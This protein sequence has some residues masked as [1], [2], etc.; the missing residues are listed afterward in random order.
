MRGIGGDIKIGAPAA[1]RSVPA[2]NVVGGRVFRSGPLVAAALGVLRH[3]SAQGLPP[4]PRLSLPGLLALYRRHGPRLAAHIGGRFTLVLHDGERRCAYVLQDAAS[5]PLNLYYA[6]GDGLFYFDTS[7]KRLLRRS[8]LPRRP[9]AAGRE[10]FLHNGFIPSERTLLEGVSKLPPGGGLRLDLETGRPHRL[11]RQAPVRR[12]GL[13]AA[14]LDYHRALRRVIASEVDR[15]PRLG[16]GLSG[17]YDSN[18]LLFLLRQARRRGCRL[19]TIGVRDEADEVRRAARIARRYPGVE[20]HVGWVGPHTLQRLPDIVW[21]LEG[22]V[23]ERG[24]F[25]Q[26]EL[27]RLARHEGCRALLCAECADQVLAPGFRA[28]P[29]PH[30]TRLGWATH[31]YEMGLM[32]VLKKNGILCNSFSV[33]TLYPYLD[34]GIVERGAR[35]APLNGRRKVLHRLWAHLHLPWSVAAHLRKAPGTTRLRPLFESEARFAAL[36]RLLADQPAESAP[37]RCRRNPDGAPDE[38]ARDLLLKGLYLRLFDVLIASGAYD[39]FFDAPGFDWSLDDIL[40]GGPS[41]DQS[42]QCPALRP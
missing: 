19:L 5:S 11:H 14:A 25:L 23:Y 9:D 26:Y 38:Q 30:P 35:L 6:V 42:S 28:G 18:L 22:A 24:I 13:L 20:H 36:R 12:G 32:L 3:R 41:R 27:A 33:D 40:A 21:R 7:L 4:A 29:P 17:G 37:D 16:V 8:G 31:P 15:I 39:A 1:A 34:E 10:A 2:L